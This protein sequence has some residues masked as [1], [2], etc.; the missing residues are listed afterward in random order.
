MAAIDLGLEGRRVLVTGASRGIGAAAARAFAD[1]GCRLAL[2]YRGEPGEAAD[3]AGALLL[4]GDFARMA[5]VRQVVAAAVAALGGLDV[6]VN[7]AG[8]MLGRVPLAGM[9]EAAIDRVFDST[10]ARSSSPA[11]RRCRRWRKAGAASST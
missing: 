7:N 8:H 4:A 10:R 11:G 1:A 5:D 9:D 6:L 2:H 3:V